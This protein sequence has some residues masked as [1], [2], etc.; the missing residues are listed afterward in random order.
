MPRSV[1]L[2]SGERARSS[3]HLAFAPDDMLTRGM[4]VLRSPRPAHASFTNRGSASLI[5]PCG[6]FHRECAWLPP[7][8]DAARAICRQLGCRAEPCPQLRGS[9]AALANIR[10]EYVWADYEDNR[11]VIRNEAEAV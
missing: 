5:N 9:W 10:S 2:L 7:K 6:P 3:G 4:H 11:L 1:Q 8:R